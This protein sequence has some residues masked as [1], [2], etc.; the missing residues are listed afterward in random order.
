MD[1]QHDE[2]L[3]RR[4]RAEMD[5]GA[6]RFEFERPGV[7]PSDVVSRPSRRWRLRWL[8]W[9]L[10]VLA[11]VGAVAWYYPRPESQPKTAGRSQ[12]GGPVPVGVATVQKGDMPVTLT[13]LGTVTPLATVTVKTQINGYLTQV[14]FQEGQM[15]K[16]GDFLA[17]IDPRPYQV[18]LEQAEG[19]LAKDQALLKNAQLDL[20]RYNTLVAQNSVATQ[21]RDTQVS[22]VAQD[23]AAIKTD[24]AQVD[25]QKLNLV[26]A[27]IVSP[28]T[29]RVG[30]RQVDAGNYVQTSDA[31]GIVI[32]TQLQPISVIF[33]LPEDNLPAVLKQLHAGASLAATAYDRTNTTELGKGNL[34][35][36]DN[37]IDTTTGMVKLRAIFDNEQE[38]LFP[39]QFV[40]VQLLVD[41]L[42][43]TNIVPTAAIQHGAPG[44]FVYVVK[45][46]QT[47][48]VQQVKLGP[49]DGQHIAVLEGL[50]PGEKVVVD[51]SDRLREG[52]K[53]T[54]AATGSP[55]GTAPGAQQDKGQPQAA[56]GQGASPP[57]DP[58]AP[59]DRRSAQPHAQRQDEGQGGGHRR[60][61]Q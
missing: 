44:A 9:V 16:K 1:D 19:Q 43:D 37:Q 48:A 35:T 56:S 20:V 57:A 4:S 47:A 2:I 26:Y 7:R 6:A 12:F 58:P 32:V 38:I 3:V 60:N 24:Q 29:G 10:L 45:P 36:V 30:L 21:T 13:G 40:N 46:D 51:G 50:Q 53:V 15:V 39:N 33:T 55:G 14:A 59:A 17:Q 23:Q 31:N 49:G 52:A 54:L 8:F 5:G 28:V 22:L 41:T 34:E 42:R 27:H 18:A 11:I 61:T 25:A